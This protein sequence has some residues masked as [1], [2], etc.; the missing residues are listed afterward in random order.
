LPGTS[1]EMPVLNG[2]A[3]IEGQLAPSQPA[4][5]PHVFA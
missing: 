3:A 4:V 1:I 2:H 5:P